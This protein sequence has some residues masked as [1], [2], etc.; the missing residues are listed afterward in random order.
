MSSS[1]NICLSGGADGADTV[2]GRTAE[3]YGHEVVHWS[4]DGHSIIDKKYKCDLDDYKLRQADSFLDLANKSIQR[5]WPTSKAF[6]NNLLRRNFYQIYWSGS[7]YAVASF[8]N[9]TSLL[10]ISGGTAW[11]CQMFVDRWLYSTNYIQDIP[12]YFFDQKSKC[13]YKW[14]GSWV[15]IIKPP[16]PSKVYAGIGTRDLTPAGR[17]AI[18]DV[19]G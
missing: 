11:A 3:R 19:Y 9:D 6:I 12:L 8:S 4:F 14:N 7:V 2:W 16:Q 5:R 15:N 18:E 13:W 17:A 10:K 1:L